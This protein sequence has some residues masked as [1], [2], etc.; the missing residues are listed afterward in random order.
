ML[1]SPTSSKESGSQWTASEKSKES[2]F[3]EEEIRPASNDPD[4]QPLL[5]EAIDVPLPPSIPSTASETSAAPASTPYDTPYHKSPRSEDECIVL[6]EL[7]GFLRLQDDV[8]ALRVRLQ[9]Q[10]SLLKYQLAV[11]GREDA[12]LMDA[13]RQSEIRGRSLSFGAYAPLFQASEA[14]RDKLGPIENEYS[15]QE[16]RLVNQE[17]GLITEGRRLRAGTVR[18]NMSGVSAQ[19][20]VVPRTS[21]NPPSDSGFTRISF[22]SSTAEVPSISGDENEAGQD[23]LEFQGPGRPFAGYVDIVQQRILNRE[24][25]G[26]PGAT[27]ASSMIH[28]E[29]AG[30]PRV[31]E[32][33]L[34][35][36]A[37][38]LPPIPPAE[39]L[40]DSHADEPDLYVIEDDLPELKSEEAN[41]WEDMEP[42]LVHDIPT[43][44]RKLWSYLDDLGGAPS[45]YMK[46]WILH[47]WRRSALDMLAYG[48]IGTVDAARVLRWSIGSLE[49]W[50]EA[51]SYHI[52]PPEGMA[53]PASKNRPSSPQSVK[54]W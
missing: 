18:F 46:R 50:T 22:E 36:A 29:S 3:Q 47:R 51:L 11:V 45:A 9:Q 33:L 52:A 39:E 13:M 53:G 44:L 30:V 2:T 43:Q 7:E 5:S 15:S 26:S 38:E 27:Q 14:A 31:N 12:H 41:D 20:P 28:I 10:R 4:L 8:T 19:Q 35:F 54:G 25:I 24:I 17:A 34:R 32:S 1:Q 49:D 16:L 40:K 48:T 6:P 37:P 42:L 21:V 23:R